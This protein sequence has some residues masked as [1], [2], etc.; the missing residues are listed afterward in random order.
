MVHKEL[1]F[2]KFS[3]PKIEKLIKF[4]VHPKCTQCT[5][6][7]YVCVHLWVHLKVS[8]INELNVSVP[9]VPKILL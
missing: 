6:K 2:V 8:K 9:N 4:W 5:Q 7:N 3:V 1:L